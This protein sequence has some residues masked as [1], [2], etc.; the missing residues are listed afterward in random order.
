[1]ES[2]FA[3]VPLIASREAVDRLALEPSVDYEPIESA[4]PEAVRAAVLKFLPQR[5]RYQHRIQHLRGLWRERYDW[6]AIG[7]GM[8]HA[9]CRLMADTSAAPGLEL[10]VADGQA[11]TETRA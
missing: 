5:E 6:P 1:M 11:E 9:L 4:S 3:G 10:P 7:R 2:V 8:A